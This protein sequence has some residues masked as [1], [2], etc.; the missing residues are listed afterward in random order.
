MNSHTSGLASL[1]TARSAAPCYPDRETDGPA[2]I[3]R[4]GPA[5]CE[6]PQDGLFTV[7]VSAPL[8]T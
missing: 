2:P 4:S 5:C 1:R 7:T 6:L 3:S 8:V